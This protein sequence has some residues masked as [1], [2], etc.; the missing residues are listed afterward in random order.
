[1]SKAEFKYENLGNGELQELIKQAFT[2]LGC[3]KCS[4]GCPMVYLFPEHFNPHK[5][6]EKL[7]DNPTEALA[8]KDIWFCASCYKCNKKCP[9]GIELPEVFLKL[10]RIAIEQ[11]GLE[12]L[13]EVIDDLQDR[14]PFYNNFFRVCY[15]PEKIPLEK[16]EVDALFE[17][18]VRELKL[19]QIPDDKGK[20]A[21]IGSGP[22]GLFAACGLRNKGYKV[23]VF[24]SRQK[25]GGMLQLTIPEFRLESETVDHD[26]DLIK[27]LGIEIKTN[28][29]IGKDVMF[30]ELF[31]EGFQAVFIATGAHHC[32]HLNIEGEN[33]PQV[34]SS[35]E[36]L[37]ANKDGTCPDM[38]EKFVVIGGGNTAMEVATTAVKYG[39]KEVSVLYRRSK[40]EIPADINEIR[41]V[42]NSGAKIQYLVTPLRFIGEE[43]LTGIECIKMELGY[44]DLSGRR[45]P[46]PVKDSNFIIDA[47]MAVVSIGEK[48]DLGYL[49]GEIMLNKEGTIAINPLTMETSMKG[50]FAGGDVILGS[51]TVA[52]AVM[53]AGRAVDGI[54]KYLIEKE[55][56]S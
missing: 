23:V 39:A 36:F 33:L 47:D 53:A 32:L 52:E 5:V 54:E 35:L 43:K 3:G 28:V 17:K 10:R 46:V 34:M 38:K 31:D 1:M 48:P 22:A 6:L 45:R 51:A 50:V 24:E 42:E 25:A 12:N 41:E 49:P 7:V 37:E 13:K 56:S 4:G 26:I 21:I 14:I 29:T 19:E 2:C 9:Q 11:N 30:H 40:D 44:P 55:K 20:V 8:A 16:K 27:G 18:H 15:H